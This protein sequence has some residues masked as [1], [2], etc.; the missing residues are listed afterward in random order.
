MRLVAL[1]A[2]VAV[3]GCGDTI[4]VVSA[5]GGTKQPH[6][7]V[8]TTGEDLGLMLDWQTV[9]SD[10][11]QAPVTIEPVEMLFANADCSGEAT[12]ATPR[13]L[14]NLAGYVAAPTGVVVEA[15]F[16]DSTATYRDIYSRLVPREAVTRCD[17]TNE[18]LSGAHAFK[19]TGVKMFPRFRSELSVE[20]R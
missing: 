20:L 6:L 16:Y 17:A 11:L 7:I 8:T 18:K 5:D 10:E 1:V 3:A 12:I 15:E 9:W 13:G 14:Q 4:Y 2:L 19:A